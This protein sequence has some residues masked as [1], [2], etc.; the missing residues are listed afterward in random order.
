MRAFAI[1]FL[2][3]MEMLSIYLVVILVL[4]FRPAGFFGRTAA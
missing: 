4:I 2:P 3:E 1:S